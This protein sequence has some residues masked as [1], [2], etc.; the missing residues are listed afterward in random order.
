MVGRRKQVWL[1]QAACGDV[2]GCRAI[3]VLIGERRTARGAKRAL[4]WRSRAILRRCAFDDGE[5]RLVK[6]DP[7]YNGRTRNAP[8]R[9]AMA[10][11]AIGRLPLNLIP[12]G[13]ARTA[14]V[15]HCY[16]Y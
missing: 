12:N 14:T 4:H 5:T 2:D 16:H 8:A 9:L 13:A 6:R 10:D 3:I 11:H 1:V 7:S 15:N